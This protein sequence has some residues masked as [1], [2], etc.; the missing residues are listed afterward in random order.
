MATLESL[1]HSIVCHDCRADPGEIHGPHC[2]VECCSVCGGQYIQCG[3][4]SHDPAFARWNG[5]WPGELEA[6]ALDMTL[7]DL[8]DT[9]LY[10]I[11]FIKPKLP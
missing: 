6:K 10:K 3:C 11:F 1:K 7:N 4:P 9:E 5:F 8:Y 2:D